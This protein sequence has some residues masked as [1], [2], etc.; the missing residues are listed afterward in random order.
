MKI[1]DWNIHTFFFQ[2]GL[3]FCLR[4]RFFARF[5]FIDSL[6]NVENLQNAI[7]ASSKKVRFR[8]FPQLM[9]VESKSRTFRILLDFLL[10]PEEVIHKLRKPVDPH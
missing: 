5:V 8:G 9:F 1:P 6:F 3:F 10:F 7:K 2:L 4:T